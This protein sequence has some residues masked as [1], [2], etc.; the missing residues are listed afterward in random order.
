[1]IFSIPL[2]KYPVLWLSG[3]FSLCLWVLLEQGKVPGS[4]SP[5]EP[6]VKFSRV[7]QAEP[8]AAAVCTVIITVPQSQWQPVNTWA[9]GV[10]HHH[11]LCLLLA[12][13]SRALCERGDTSALEQEWIKMT[14][15]LEVTREEVW[16]PCSRNPHSSFANE[17]VCEEEPYFHLLFNGMKYTAPKTLK[18]RGYFSSLVQVQVFSLNFLV[19]FSGAD[20]SGDWDFSIA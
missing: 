14:V 17:Q 11:S 18:N 2:D 9:G 3:G 15:K 16:S 6:P 4:M 1:M 10:G 20:N 5:L 19:S 13:A 8:W 12:A 7:H